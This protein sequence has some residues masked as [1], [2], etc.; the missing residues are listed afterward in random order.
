MKK[1]IIISASISIALC[2]SI[3]SSCTKQEDNLAPITKN[4][5]NIEITFVE[6]LS[7]TKTEF[8]GK[9]TRWSK[10]DKVTFGQYAFVEEVGTLKSSS[11]TLNSAA[12]TLTA[13]IGLFNDPDEGTN[14]CYF[15]VYPGGSLTYDG[16]SLKNY[17]TSGGTNPAIRATIPQTQKPVVTDGVPTGFD[18]NADL[19]ISNLKDN[20]TRETEGENAGKYVIKLTYD[21]KVA[22][23]KMTI[24]NLQSD[25]PVTSIEI[26][27]NK[28]NGSA[29]TVAGQMWY[30]LLTGNI[31]NTSTAY[32]SVI[33]D[34]SNNPINLEEDGEDTKMMAYFCCRPFSLKE[35]DV[36]CVVVKTQAGEVFTKFVT[37]GTGRELVFEANKGTQFS[38]DMLSAVKSNDWVSVSEYNSGTSVKTATK[39]CFLAKETTGLTI[40]SGKFSAIPESTFLDPTF[41]I[42]EYFESKGTAVSASSIS[43]FNSGKNLIFSC[44]G[45][46]PDSWYI[47][48]IKLVAVDTDSNEVVGYAFTKIKTDW[49]SLTASTRT[50]GGINFYFYGKGLV[51]SS[52][53]YRFIATDALPEGQTFEEYYTNTLAPGGISSSTLSG[54]NE[55]GKSGKGYYTTTYYTD[56]STTGTMTPGTSYTI[57]IKVN[58]ERGE[59][60][61]CYASANAGGTTE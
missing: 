12:E 60:K 11:V 32:K 42:A 51:S 44:T 20:L 8:Y 36:F 45:L 4:S 9:T 17:L 49:F 61:F 14:S 39:I 24:K 47:V 23:G 46:E 29:V 55:N 7:E 6:E 16:T 27:A 40:S 22:I 38:V 18:P 26:S 57:M 5:R 19:L 25:S 33:L 28:E 30:N 13:K 2:A 41:D 43:S 56:K 58:N 53:N 31:S 48:A 50:A 15:A 34:Y 52:R 1:R 59:T 54:I 21:R 35:N 3:F 37:V 10:G